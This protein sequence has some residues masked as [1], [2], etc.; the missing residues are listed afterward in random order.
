[1][2]EL[3][4]RTDDLN[5]GR[6]KLNKAIQKVDYFQK[7]IDEIV[8]EG[9]SSVEAAQARVDAN[10]N[11]YSTLKQRLDTEQQ[12]TKQEINNLQNNK[13]DK[14]EL[15]NVENRLSQINGLSTDV[16]YIYVDVNNGDDDNNGTE[17]APFKT[18]QKAVDTIPKII[19]KD[20]HIVCKPGIY[21]EE[22]VVQSITGA[23]IF[24]TCPEANQD[25][26]QETGFSVV[27]ISFYDC[28]G[29]CV[30]QNFDAF[31]GDTFKARAHI[32]FSRCAYGSVS[33]CRFDSWT[34][35]NGTGKASVL[36]DGSIGSL[37][38]NY[39]HNQHR[40]L[41]V[42]NGS[43]VRVDANNTSTGD[44]IYGMTAQAATIYKNGLV[45]FTAQIPEQKLQ[46]GQIW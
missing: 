31:K 46:G 6:E 25:P 38:S 37:Q 35:N 16:K 29:Y 12:Q 24:I 42:M 11:V 9:D 8:V 43:Q 14:T 17:N 44:S 33:K 13:A 40:C 2:A 20:H 34:K 5:T 30:V 45:S 32:V 23:G 4:Q 21:D 10:G 28:H 18:I 27:S 41:H 7:Q 22:V 39:W 15:E 3:I 36:Y 26:T 19:N 1:M